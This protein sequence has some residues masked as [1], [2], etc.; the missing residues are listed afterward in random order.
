[1]VAD[2]KLVPLSHI[3]SEMESLL[4]N[5]DSIE[6]AVFNFTYTDFSFQY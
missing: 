4:A 6:S 3:G 2:I 1:M 5:A